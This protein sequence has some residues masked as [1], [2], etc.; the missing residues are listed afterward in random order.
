MTEDDPKAD[1]LE[2]ELDDM[3]QRSEQLDEQIEAARDDWER[4]KGDSGVP[5]APPAD[6]DR[7]AEREPE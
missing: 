6:E 5:G 1:E 2:R 7:S 3:E 4:K